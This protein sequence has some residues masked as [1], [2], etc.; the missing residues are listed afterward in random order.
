MAYWIAKA[1]AH[2]KGAFSGAAHRAGMSTA[3]YERHVLA[4]GSHAR[5]RLRKRAVLSRT[6]RM[7]RQRHQAEED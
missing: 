5:S 3:A 7:L 2:N 1:T 4:T 6:L